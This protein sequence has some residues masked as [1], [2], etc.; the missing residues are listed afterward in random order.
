MK[1]LMCLVLAGVV[2]GSATAGADDG[3]RGDHRRDRDD[4]R[5]ERRY[6]DDRDHRRYDR[7][8]GYFSVREVH[9]IREYY[10]PRYKRIPPG[11][12]KRYYRDAYLPHGWERC[13]EPI[14]VY[15]ERDLV[16]LP[17][18]YRRGIIDGQVVVFNNRG[19]IIDVAVLF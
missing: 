4:R 1:S 9:V 11:H 16:V 17:H 10:R 5:Y 18:G 2:I 8:R 15:L 6:D 3:R 7:R 12:A 14:P 13:V 19:L